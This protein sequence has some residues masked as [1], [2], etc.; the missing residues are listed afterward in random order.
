MIIMIIFH[1]IYYIR[2]DD[3]DMRKEDCISSE[4]R[5]LLGPVV[6]ISNLNFLLQKVGGA[7]TC[8][9]RARLFVINVS[10]VGKVELDLLSFSFDGKIP[11]K[12]VSQ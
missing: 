9:N 3:D 7:H 2:G 4:S 6:E 8:Q 10:F 5:L 12:V 11:L 1:V